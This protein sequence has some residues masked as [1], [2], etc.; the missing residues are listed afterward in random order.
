M[1]NETPP[2][3]AGCP[4]AG[5]V[6]A[7]FAGRLPAQRHRQLRPHLSDCASCRD[8]YGR[9]LQLAALDPEAVPFEER[10]ARGLG[11]RPRRLLGLP[12]AGWSALVGTAALAAVLLVVQ[13]GNHG[14]AARGPIHPDALVLSPGAPASDVLVFRTDRAGGASLLTEPLPRQAELAVAYRNAGSW[15][16]LLVFGRDDTGA[17]HWYQPP[18]TDGAEDPQAV[19]LAAGPALHELPRAVAHRLDGA[20]L[21]LCALVTNQPLSVRQVEARLQ[22]Q[23]DRAPEEALDGAGAIACRTLEVVP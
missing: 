6:D 18:W 16:G 10:V 11:L 17:V 5:E 7:Y 8:R 15:Q 23:P 13:G 9:Q 14:F 12:A 21:T 22:L 1:A 4:R 20:R 3:T 2:T 19:A